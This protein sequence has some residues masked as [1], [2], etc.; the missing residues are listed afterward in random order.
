[1][2]KPPVNHILVLVDGTEASFH[3]ADRAIELA[4]ALGARLTAL[5]VVDTET[6][7]QLLN[8]KILVDA[9]MGE[10]EK[11]LEESARRQLAEVRERALDQ[12]V[13]IEEVLIT[14]SVET[15]VPK[16]VQDR[17]VDLIALGGFQSTKIT[18]DLVARQ[19]Q[20]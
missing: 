7:R 12:K 18:R 1:M 15:V 17:G 10:F 19:H 13:V 9:E 3:A 14:G 4:R 16:E 20:Q 5:A 6:L 11:E 2:A 8:V